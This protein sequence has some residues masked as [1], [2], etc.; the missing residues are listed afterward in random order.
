MMK[1]TMYVTI[2][3]IFKDINF[4]RA[5]NLLKNDV[6]LTIA[7]QKGVYKICNFQVV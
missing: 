6:K 4:I 5:T 1:R 2:P 3:I 7:I